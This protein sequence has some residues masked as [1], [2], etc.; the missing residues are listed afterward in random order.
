MLHVQI[1]KTAACALLPASPLRLTDMPPNL[2]ASLLK[3]KPPSWKTPY[4]LALLR[5]PLSWLTTPLPLLFSPLVTF[6]SLASR[7]RPPHP[8]RSSAF[9][10]TLR[11]VCHHDSPCP[12][13]RPNASCCVCTAPL[14]TSDPAAALPQRLRG[15]ASLGSASDKCFSDSDSDDNEDNTRENTS[16]RP[17]E[18]PESPAQT[19]QPLAKLELV[20]PAEEVATSQP[21]LEAPMPRPKTPPNLSRLLEDIARTPTPQRTARG[22]YAYPAPRDATKGKAARRRNRDISRDRQPDSGELPSLPPSAPASRVPSRGAPENVYQGFIDRDADIFRDSSPYPTD[23]PPTM[24]ILLPNVYARVNP[25]LEVIPNPMQAQD[26]HHLHLFNLENAFDRLGTTVQ[27]S[28]D[29]TAITARSASGPDEKYEITEH[30]AV[31]STVLLLGSKGINWLTFGSF[32]DTVSTLS[33]FKGSL[34]DFKSFWQNVIEEARA[35]DA[36]RPFVNKY[37]PDTHR[38]LRAQAKLWKE[39]HDRAVHS[40]NTERH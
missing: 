9:S 25:K 12:I 27:T 31:V 6:P 36:L 30:K 5:P 14:P 24:P 7:L 40:A 21:A 2:P 8:H 3:S 11:F 29:G 17:A 33:P 28:K 32:M 37:C 1:I 18:W 39:R 35:N 22:S 38:D 26:V 20:A 15:G 16:L 19:S 23:V 13:C 10:G 4:S 34:Q